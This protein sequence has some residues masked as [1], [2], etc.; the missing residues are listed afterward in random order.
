MSCLRPDCLGTLQY[1]ARRADLYR[2][3]PANLQGPG[4][5]NRPYPARLN[6]MLPH[7]RGEAPPRSKSPG[8]A[9]RD[10]PPGRLALPPPTNQGPC[11]TGRYG[12]RTTEKSFGTGSYSVVCTEF[13]PYLGE[14]YGMTR[15]TTSIIRED[16]SSPRYKVHFVTA[17]DGGLAVGCECG[18]K[19]KGRHSSRWSTA[20]RCW[21]DW[22]ALHHGHNYRLQEIVWNE[23]TQTWED[24][25]E[26]YFDD[27][28]GV[29]GRR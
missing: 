1:Y 21:E 26:G 13:R 2:R 7:L 11:P 28:P 20:E 27:N 18:V 8:R 10:L 9:L 25:Y 4:T 17:D 22:R 14:H 15:R 19:T 24:W 12:A 3:V 6:A 16:V 29:T 23:K 5:P